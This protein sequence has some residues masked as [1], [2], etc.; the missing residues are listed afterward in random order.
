M[1]SSPFNKDQQPTKMFLY[2]AAPAPSSVQ[3]VLGTKCLDIGKPHDKQDWFYPR[4]EQHP[5]RS[6]AT[7][8]DPKIDKEGV[9]ANQV[10]FS[11]QIPLP[12]NNY[13][14]DMSR[15]FQNLVS[16]LQ[17]DIDYKKTIPFGMTSWLLYK[18]CDHI[19]HEW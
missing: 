19:S 11:F 12:K 6:V 17:V 5:C 7:L 13:I 14:L 1:N 10:V 4:G 18:H 9:T 2:F 8:D 15:W 3:S 16:I